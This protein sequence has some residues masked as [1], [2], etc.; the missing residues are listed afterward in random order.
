MRKLDSGEFCEIAGAPAG[1]SAPGGEV[2]SG[3]D[4]VLDEST[5]LRLSSLTSDFYAE[6]ADSFSETR[7][8]AWVGWERL[9]EEVA[10]AMQP[11]NP[12]V[13]DLACGNM[14]FARFLAE[15]LLQ[16]S[17]E[18][19]AADNCSGLASAG[20]VAAAGESAVD[21]FA[22]SDVE[23]VSA[24]D[25]FAP[26]ADCASNSARRFFESPQSVYSSDPGSG[27]YEPVKIGDRIACSFQQLDIVSSL[28]ANSLAADLAVCD[29][30]CDLAV[31]FGFMH[32]IPLVAWRRQLLQ[33]LAAKVRPGGYVA[34]SFWRFMSSPK[35]AKK[36]QVTTAQACAEL[37]LP[38]LPENDYLLGWQQ[39]RGSYR[40][41]HHFDEAEIASF[42]QALG[43][44]ATLVARYQADG[45]PGNLN[46]YLIWRVF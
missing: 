25:G 3:R 45:K 34:V 18:Y 20:G 44:R 14:R 24:A 41:C 27:G 5:A 43:P 26:T 33:A 2:A 11:Q 30:S 19:L 46:E 4:A 29:K 12:R 35:L 7:T 10:P 15:R 9:L 39:T 17:I 28:A 37:S 42:E 6:N 38:E 23:S 13:L 8:N 40:Y 22:N 21:G 31:A 32:H 16:C 1:G 36:A